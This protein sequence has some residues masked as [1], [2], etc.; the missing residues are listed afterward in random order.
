MNYVKV[1]EECK[2]LTDMATFENF[3]SL[4]EEMRKT[5]GTIFNFFNPIG[6]SGD[7]LQEFD[8]IIDGIWLNNDKSTYYLSRDT[9]KNYCID[10][11]REIHDNDEDSTKKND[12]LRARWEELLKKEMKTYTIVFPLYGAVS[13]RL[14]KK[15]RLAV[16]LIKKRSKA[17]VK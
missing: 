13:S 14:C 2:K 7:N 10:V 12:K 4:H 11:I 1:V 5:G 16:K 9:I 15:K 17:V 3:K 6:I 8:K